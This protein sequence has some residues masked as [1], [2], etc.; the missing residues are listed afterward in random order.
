MTARRRLS[1]LVLALSFTLPVALVAQSAAG[2]QPDTF[3]D[4]SILKPPAG[5]KVAIVVFEDLGCPGCAAAH[6]LELAAAKRNNVPLVRYDFPLAQHVWTFDGAVCARYL[7]THVS[8]V[9]ANE[10]RTAVFASQRL[11]ENKEDLVQF[12]QRWFQQHH[13]PLPFSLDPDGSLAKQVKADFDLGMK[14]NVTQTPTVIVV[15]RGQYQV[16]CGLP[17]GNNDPTRLESFVEAALAKDK[18]AAPIHKR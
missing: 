2:N 13:Q 16:V 3:R 15:S 6:P 17:D 9:V 7:Q 10:Y 12:N 11:I 4:K 18:T 1:F 8:P 14:L 5:A